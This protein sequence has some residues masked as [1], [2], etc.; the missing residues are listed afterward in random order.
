MTRRCGCG[1]RTA[2]RELACL[3]GHEDW[4]S[5][6]AFDPR[7]PADRQRVVGQDGAGV[8]RGRA[9]RE[10]ACLRG[11]EGWVMSVAFDPDGRRIVSGSDDKTVRV[12]DADERR[13]SSPASA[14]TRTGSRAWRSTRRPAHRQ[15]VAVTRR[16]GCGTRRAARELA[17]LRGHE[18]AVTSVAFDPTAGA[19]SAGRGTRRCGC[20]TRTSGRELACLRGHEDTVMSV[21]FDPDGRRIVSGSWDKTVRVWDADE[22]PRSSPASRGHERWVSERGVR[23]RRP[24]AS[25]AGRGTRRC[26]CGTRTAAASSRAS[27]GTRTRS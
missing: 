12:W 25:S 8:G 13:A 11:H 20:G 27:A 6:V 15:R 4:V 3:R 16:C 7:R 17:C 14:G 24:A 21:A 26:G 2:A 23:R 22:R 18:G 10:L 5:S 9:A 19:S 1:T